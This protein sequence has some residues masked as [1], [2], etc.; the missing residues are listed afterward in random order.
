M[1]SYLYLILIL[2]WG[3]GKVE[4]SPNQKFDSNTPSDL[5]KKNIAK[6]YS[7]SND[8]TVRF[9]LTGDTQRAYSACKSMVNKINSLRGVDF[10]VINGDISDFGLYQEMEWVNDIYSNIN[11]PYIGILG[12]HDISA[13]G[14]DIYRRMYG[15]EN[16]CFV[17]D[18]VKFVCYDSNSREYNFNGSIP[19]M[20]WLS[21]EMKPQAGVKNYVAISHIPSF[22]DD[23]DPTLEKPYA[24]LITGNKKILA[25]MHAHI[26]HSQVYYPYNTSTPF[27]IANTAAE[28][29]FYLIEIINGKLSHQVINF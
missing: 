27:I 1:K 13:N 21:A 14:K 7:Q 8:D 15:E 9:V 18:S 29:E 19:N 10:V 16:F 25:S 17:Y 26:N 23:F 11:V 4:Y 3:C 5:N 2:L 22:I 24:D 28:K 12:N 6:L 20:S